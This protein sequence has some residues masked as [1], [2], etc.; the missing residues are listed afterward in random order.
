MLAKDL[1]GPQAAARK[2]DLLSA[3]GAFALGRGA[4]EQRVVLRFIT[5][6]TARY[7]WQN[8][9]LS[10]GQHDIARLWN[11]TTRTVKREILW[12]RRHGW[13]EVTRQGSRGTVSRYRLGLERIVEDTAPYWPA[14]GP[15][16]VARMSAK[17][18][19]S[20]QKVVTVDFQAR[21]IAELE[22][23]PRWTDTLRALQK[24]DPSGY[25]SWYMKL[26]FVSYDG[27]CLTIAAPNSFVRAYLETH[28]RQALLS[29]AG[30]AFGAVT[31]LRLVET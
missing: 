28:L 10:I 30:L 3:M 31:S 15:D 19:V 26:D 1:I 11:V 23:D 14:V 22:G 9:E 8:A 18:T 13:L 17:A 29:Q 7:N 2:Y 5:L 20:S 6:I 27:G 21:T 16:F 25:A 24:S 4:T 12:L